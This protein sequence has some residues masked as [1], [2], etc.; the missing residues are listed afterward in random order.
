MSLSF[1]VEIDSKE[2]VFTYDEAAGSLVVTSIAGVERHIICASGHI[3]NVDDARE[4]A[5]VLAN[6]FQDNLF[7]HP[8]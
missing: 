1:S 7:W 6:K 3:S 5:K 4:Y 8:V 2:I